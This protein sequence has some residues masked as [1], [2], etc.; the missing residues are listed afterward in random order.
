MD[1]IFKYVK[2]K[3]KT[4]KFYELYDFAKKNS[5]DLNHFYSYNPY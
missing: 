3:Y 2:E 5:N 1:Y 4:N